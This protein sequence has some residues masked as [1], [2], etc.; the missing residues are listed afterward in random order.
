MNPFR[1]NITFSMLF[2]IAAFHEKFGLTQN[3]ALVGIASTPPDQAANGILFDKWQTENR[4][5][6][7]LEEWELRKT[8]L[9][10]E[11]MEYQEAHESGD[12]EGA[13]DA[14][15][16]IVY[17][18]LGTA[19]RRGWDFQTAFERVHEANMAKERGEPGNS[20]YGSGFDIIKPEGWTAPD[21]SDLVGQPKQE[22]V[23]AEEETVPDTATNESG[24]ETA[25]DEE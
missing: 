13:L 4:D 18:A 9:I 23:E 8:R 21:L 17:I 3:N 5:K 11:A 12:D 7:L 14:L 16:D 10:D 15:V 20:K 24:T 1:N 6:M 19:Y 2:A 22:E 25:T